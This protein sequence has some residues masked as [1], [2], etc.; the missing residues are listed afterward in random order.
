M[1]WKAIFFSCLWTY[2]KYATGTE[3][4]VNRN[5]DPMVPKCNFILQ[6]LCNLLRKQSHWS[7]KNFRIIQGLQMILDSWDKDFILT[8]NKFYL[9]YS[10]QH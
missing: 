6:G 5:I 1:F 3:D 7:V 10:L 2:A 9:F 4:G 8:A